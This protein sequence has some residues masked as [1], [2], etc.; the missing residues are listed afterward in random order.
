MHQLVKS[1]VNQAELHTATHSKKQQQKKHKKL[2]KQK[3]DRL[4]KKKKNRLDRG[5]VRL[6]H[7]DFYQ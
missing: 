2:K 7:A 3:H 5:S 1:K 6:A 4:T